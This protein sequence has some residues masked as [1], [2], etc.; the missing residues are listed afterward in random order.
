MNQ[1]KGQ[2]IYMNCNKKNIFAARSEP[3]GF[4]SEP[5]VAK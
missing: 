3:H 4:I 1:P 5:C 2:H